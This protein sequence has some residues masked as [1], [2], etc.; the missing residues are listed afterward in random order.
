MPLGQGS[1]ELPN[2]ARDGAAGG[3]FLW[4]QEMVASVTFTDTGSNRWICSEYV[5]ERIV[6]GLTS[7]SA[8]VLSA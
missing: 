7:R 1:T 3:R 2:L 8:G 6:H 4:W 5:D